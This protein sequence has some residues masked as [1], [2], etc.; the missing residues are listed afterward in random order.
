M[1]MEGE[2]EGQKASET[3]EVTNPESSPHVK[4]GGVCGVQ[5]ES[6]FRFNSE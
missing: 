5:Y 2:E 6:C 1:K 4:R 3:A